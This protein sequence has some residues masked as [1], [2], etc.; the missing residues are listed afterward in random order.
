MPH[1]A[2]DQLEYFNPSSP[3]L[4]CYIVRKKCRGLRNMEEWSKER[5]NK[6][7]WEWGLLLLPGQENPASSPPCSLAGGAQSAHS[8]WLV[9]GSLCLELV[10]QNRAAIIL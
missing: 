9:L 6:W 2:W 5:E 10:P 1:Q 3:P 8:P 4:F 7:G